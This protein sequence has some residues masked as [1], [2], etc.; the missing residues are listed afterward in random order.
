MVGNP[1]LRKFETRHLL[2]IGWALGKPIRTPSIPIVNIFSYDPFRGL[3][4]N[5]SVFVLLL[6]LDQVIP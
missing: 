1:D 5:E 2:S 3:D 6:G 4:V